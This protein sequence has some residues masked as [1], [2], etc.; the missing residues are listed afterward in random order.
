MTALLFRDDAY[1][2]EFDATVT[3]VNERGGIVLDQT[4]FY[5]TSGG[6]PGDKGTLTAEDGTIVEIGTTIKA[7]GDIVHV[8]GEDQPTLAPGSKVH[9]TIDWDFR[10]QLMR[11]HTCMHLVC[12]IVPCGV[13]GGQVGIDKSRL[14]FD[15]GE[16]T[17][18]KEEITEK[19]N[20]LIRE[21]HPV[22][23]Q[24]I[25]DEELNASPDLVRT[26]SV[27]PPRGSGKVRLLKI[28][29]GVD[30]Q[31]CG[32][33]HVKNTGEIGPVRV[34]KIENKGKRNRRVNIVFDTD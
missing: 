23:A 9:G 16:H 5:Y 24:W 19:L 7:D 11:M 25:T 6:Q 15:V 33:T 32:G 26:M 14:D 8:P 29:E 22:T 1:Q 2:T 28:G 3:A 13:T 34:S 20:A 30:L 12:S 17:L 18:D 31:P 21:N 27:Q 4:L 10:H